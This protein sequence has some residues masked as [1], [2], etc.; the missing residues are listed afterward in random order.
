MRVVDIADPSV[1][2][3]VG[4]YDTFPGPSG[5]FNG[6]WS[7]CPYLPS[8][9]ILGGD[10]TG[11]LYIWKFNNT[12]AGRIYGTVS[13][14]LTGLPIDSVLITIAETGR[15]T[16]SNTSG[17]FTIGE[18]PGSYTLSCTAYGYVNMVFSNFIITGGDSLTFNVLMPP[19]IVGIE[20]SGGQ[21]CEF[22]LSQNYPNPFNPE[23]KIGFRVSGSGWVSLKVFDVLG[24]EVASLVKEK[25][26][27]GTHMVT[28]DASKLTSGVYFYR[29]SAGGFVETR[30]L[31]LLK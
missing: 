17:A 8:G 21:P 4:Y 7:A 1:P 9:K 27:A 3:E 25:K 10:R 16:R 24:R 31:L 22:T 6:L 12:Q 28:F 30:K 5:G 14:S 15:A 11:G 19:V 23:T 20:Q 18:L 13:D 29:L 26:E 2:V